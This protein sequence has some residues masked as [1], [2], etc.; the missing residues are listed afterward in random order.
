[1]LASLE[2]RWA[3]VHRALIAAIGVVEVGTLVTS[4]RRPRRLQVDES[5]ASA[6]AAQDRVP[7]RKSQR[8]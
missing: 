6:R 8:S 3:V 1:L 4:S 2:P 7:M 5:A